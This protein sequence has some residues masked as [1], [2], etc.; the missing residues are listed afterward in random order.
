MIKII[1]FSSLFLTLHLFSRH[2]I[3]WVFFG[4]LS[5]F[6]GG[7][8]VFFVSK[9]LE[10]STKQCKK[11]ILFPAHFRVLSVFGF[12]VI[13]SDIVSGNLSDCRSCKKE[14]NLPSDLFCGFL[15]YTVR[16]FPSNARRMGSPFG[17][18]PTHARTHGTVREI[19]G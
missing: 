9:N 15:E 1:C 19:K 16:I 18:F 10:R 6:F 13:Q 12:S 7:L 8:S 3:S 2:P 17:I 4:G 5:V 14:S 11:E